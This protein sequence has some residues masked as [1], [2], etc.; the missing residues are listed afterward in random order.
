MATPAEVLDH[1]AESREGSGIARA[2]AAAKAFRSLMSLSVDDKRGLAAMVAE[3]V[4]PDLV[5]RIEAESGHDLSREQ[6]QAVIDMAGRLDA[7][8]LDDLRR[9]VRDPEARAEA[10]RA[11]AATAATGMAADDD[12]P[13]EVTSPEVPNE[14]LLEDLG[15][16]AELVEVEPEP[17]PRYEA[18]PA[19]AP[20][21]FESIFDTLPDTPGFTPPTW[22]EPEQPVFPPGLDT[23]TVEEVDLTTRVRATRQPLVERLR[24]ET[25]NAGRLR[26]LRANLPSLLDMDTIGRSAV[27]DAIPDGW[28][29]RRALALLLGAGVLSASELPAL[30]SL[31]HRPTNRAWICASAIEAGMLTIDEAE[32]LLEPRAVE[33]LRTRYG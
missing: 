2:R 5:P 6:V 29:R 19:P 13:D 10:L 3:R 20:R 30:V 7:D 4:A 33:R 14:E 28:A 32:P 8:A 15:V 9:T 12:T 31:L 25:N 18:A 1:F 16:E 26:V 22:D 17:E 21:A 27:L 11:V 23:A 24:L